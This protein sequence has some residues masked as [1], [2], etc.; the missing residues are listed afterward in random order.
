M[1]NER[2][3]ERKKWCHYYVIEKMVSLNHVIE[4]KYMQKGYLT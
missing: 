3:K 2:G 4:N 1:K